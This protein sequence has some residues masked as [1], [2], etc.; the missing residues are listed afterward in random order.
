MP[1]TRQAIRDA[2]DRMP[3]RSLTVLVRE[4]SAWYVSDEVA[5]I[6]DRLGVEQDWPPGWWLAPVEPGERRMCRRLREALEDLET[7]GKAP[8]GREQ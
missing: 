1:P 6:L 5:A 8:S 3:L 4:W 2:L 7:L